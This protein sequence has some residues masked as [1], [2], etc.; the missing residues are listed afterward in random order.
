MMGQGCPSLLNRLDIYITKAVNMYLI[1]AKN[2]NKFLIHIAN[3]A[4]HSIC[5]S[6]I[7]L[8][9]WSKTTE[10]DPNRICL[11]CKEKQA[12]KKKYEGWTQAMYDEQYTNRCESLTE[13]YKK[14]REAMRAI[15]RFTKE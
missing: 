3:E 10:A 12:K 5:N 6:A 7:A 15:Y 4:G 13:S 9:I 2:A 11:V 1:R 14:E 8:G